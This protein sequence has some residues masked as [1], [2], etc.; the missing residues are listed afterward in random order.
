M[1]RNIVTFL[2]VFCVLLFLGFALPYAVNFLLMK[3]NFINNQIPSG[4]SVFVL[5]NNVE[6][7][8]LK[9]VICNFI[10]KFLCFS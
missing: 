8:A 6:V 2:K 9:D 5:Q 3:F 1:S 4:N 10:Q 7:L